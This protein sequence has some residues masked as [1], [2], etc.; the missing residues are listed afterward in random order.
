MTKLQNAYLSVLSLAGVLGL[1]SG[2]VS[3]SESVICTD[4]GTLPSVSVELMQSEDYSQC[5]VLKIAV[6]ANVDWRQVRKRTGLKSLQVRMMSFLQQHQM[7]V[8]RVTEK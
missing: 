8:L 1:L 7:K 2:A 3:C 4:C 6:D 5:R